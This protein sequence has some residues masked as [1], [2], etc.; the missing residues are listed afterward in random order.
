MIK[1]LVLALLPLVAAGCHDVTC[2][3]PAI[4]SG[5]GWCHTEVGPP[6]C[7]CPISTPCPG[8]CIPDGGDFEQPVRC[9]GGGG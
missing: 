4:F 1:R 8:Y 9:D 2:S 7:K 6:P 5:P 3:C